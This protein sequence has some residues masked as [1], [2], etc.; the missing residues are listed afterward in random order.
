MKKIIIIIL[1]FIT[2]NNAKAQNSTAVKNSQ[3]KKNTILVTEKNYKVVGEKL[4]TT[5]VKSTKD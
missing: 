4:M 3:L 1:A 2:L 5:I